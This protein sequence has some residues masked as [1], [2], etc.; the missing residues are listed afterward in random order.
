MAK[1][2]NWSGI[3]PAVTTQFNADSSLNLKATQQSI[4]HLL[5][6]GVHG[7]I[8]LGTCG[9]NCSLTAEEKRAVISAAKEVAGGKVPVLSGVSEFTTA[10]GAQYAKDAQKIGLDGLMVLPGM[11][12]KSDTRETVEHFRTIARASDLPVM[13]YNN[14][15]VY[16]VDVKPEDFALLADEKNIVAIKESSDDPRRITDLHNIHGD[17]FTLF[18]GVDDLVMESVVL[19]IDGWISGLTDVFPEESIVLWDLLLQNRFAEARSIYR[20]FTP[21]LHLDTKIKLV[22]YIKLGQQIVG[23]GSEKVRAPRLELVGE[24]RAYVTG[25][26]E[27]ALKNRPVLATRKAAQ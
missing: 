16:G 4:E 21:L 20:W 7:L 27:A 18:C 19:G 23:L 24:E 22:Q 10:S 1:A 12:Y 25:L 17:R 8:M 11:V 6:T 9:E 15:L 3:Y 13:I 2:V 5:K 26:Y 14:P